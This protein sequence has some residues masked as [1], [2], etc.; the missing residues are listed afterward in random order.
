MKVSIITELSDRIARDYG[1]GSIVQCLLKGLTVINVNYVKHYV[2][3]ADVYLVEE[4]RI[5]DKILPKIRDKKHIVHL[6]TL[7]RPWEPGFK[8]L[9]LVYEHATAIIVPSERIKIEACKDYPG[10][11][12]KIY[13]VYNGVDTD[14]W[15]PLL[16]RLH[17][18]YILY[19]GRL[20]EYKNWKLLVSEAKKYRYKLLLVGNEHNVFKVDDGICILGYVSKRTLRTLYR[21]AILHVLPSIGEP[22]GLVSLEA[23][24]CGTPSAVS[25][26]AGVSEIIPYDDLKFD[27]IEEGIPLDRLVFAA[28]KYRGVVRSIAQK[29]N[30]INYAKNIYNVLLEVMR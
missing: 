8:V 29:Y 30:C 2:D 5:Y 11:C 6:H 7:P 13:I 10:A 12:D 23:M 21:R 20:A 27:P 16:P 18:N 3:D 25:I 24:A 19:V 17:A 28:E 22:F 26:H 15:R 1:Y 4:W 14:Y 9:K